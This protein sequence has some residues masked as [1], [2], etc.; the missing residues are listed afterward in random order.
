M[1]TD[2]FITLHNVNYFKSFMFQIVQG[3]LALF[4]THTLDMKD[5]FSTFILVLL[6]SLLLDFYNI[7]RNELFCF[8]SVQLSIS[9]CLSAY[10]SRN[11]THNLY[12]AYPPYWY[13]FLWGSVLGDM[14]IVDL[15]N[16]ILIMWPRR[17]RAVEMFYKQIWQSYAKLQM[18]YI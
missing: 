12:L 8:L 9:F 7:P 10:L 17:T 14:Y 16:L 11:L 3:N 2:K 1:A 5:Q 13:A 18:I 15:V 4:C 6:V